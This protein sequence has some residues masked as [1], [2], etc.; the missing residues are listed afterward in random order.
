MHPLNACFNKLWL[1]YYGTYYIEF[2]NVFVIIVNVPLFT[3][4]VV[5]KND[6]RARP[7]HKMNAVKKILFLAV[8]AFLLLHILIPHN[9]REEMTA[10][11]HRSAH[12]N[13]DG[14]ID[15]IGLALHE[16]SGH[17][18]QVYTTQQSSFDK[19]IELDSGEA[20]YANF[21]ISEA[22]LFRPFTP[23]IGCSINNLNLFFCGLRGP[24][25]HD[26]FL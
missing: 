24:P 10:G 9:H 20:E 1:K 8:G 23:I 3:M 14:I 7:S 19:K 13:A 22:S 15:F 26:Y 21:P 6:S 12:E 18:A 5:Q 2:Q 25:A 17:D 11:Q 16:G 4:I